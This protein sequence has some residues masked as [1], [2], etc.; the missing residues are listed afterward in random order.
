LYRLRRS[1][2][3][4]ILRGPVE[5]FGK[6]HLSTLI[7]LIIIK[8]ENYLKI[9]SLIA[10]GGREMNHWI[11]K[12]GDQKIYADVLGEKYVFDNTHS[13]KVTA[14]D[15]FIYLS[16]KKNRYEFIGYG[17]VN[18]VESRTPV[19]LEKRN[20]RVK[21]IY[22]AYLTDLRWF[23]E[24]LDFS[25]KKGQLNRKAVGIENA[26]GWGISIP[27]VES[28]MFWD[29]VKLAQP[30]R[31]GIQSPSRLLTP[32]KGSPGK[33]WSHPSNT[34]NKYLQKQENEILRN[35][36]FEPFNFSD[37]RKKTLRYLVLRR[38]QPKFREALLKAYGGKCAIT[39]FDV[40]E[41]LQAAHIYPYR[42]E[43]TNTVNNGLLLRSDIHDL[44]DLGLI[45]IDTNEMKV[46]LHD[47]LLSSSYRVLHNVSLRL[48]EKEE[49]WP[50]KVYLDWHRA[51][52]KNQK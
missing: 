48:P 7:E 50:N 14:G 33:E 10:V 43:D 25:S 37:A 21:T 28:K 8:A 3:N 4:T 27:R 49:L 31:V 22:T 51:W 20:G 41:A 32:Q 35:G 34:T 47:S 1:F 6:N 12:V 45:T 18:K 15:Y 44:F 19:G 17:K 11:F 2:N 9:I 52:W 13:I 39:G 26:L 36:D 23:S 42:G 38:G 5:G 46:Q 29:L 24:P 16:T 30:E 40:V